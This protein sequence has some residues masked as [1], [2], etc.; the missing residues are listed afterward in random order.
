MVS[1]VFYYK[2]CYSAI[3]I[4]ILQGYDIC[5]YIWEHFRVSISITILLYPYYYYVKGFKYVIKNIIVKWGG[6]KQQIWK[7]LIYY[8]G[9]LYHSFR[10]R[11]RNW[12]KYG[13]NCARN[14]GSGEKGSACCMRWLGRELQGDQNKR[15]KV[16]IRKVERMRTREEEKKMKRTQWRRV[17]DI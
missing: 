14:P 17:Q 1:Q 9:E 16:C 11:P 12:V 10:Y 7:R 2:Y 13:V 4:C 5:I 15:E 8:M 6:E 3:V